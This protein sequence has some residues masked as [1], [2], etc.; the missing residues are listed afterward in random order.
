[1]ENNNVTPP[2]SGGTAKTIVIGAK[3]PCRG[4]LRDCPNIDRCGG[5]PWRMSAKTTNENTTTKR[6]TAGNVDKDE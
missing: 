3:F 2:D 6:S 1:M 4:C 5:V